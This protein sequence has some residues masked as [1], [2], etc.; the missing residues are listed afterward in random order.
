[1]AQWPF[2]SYR[3]QDSFSE[4]QAVNNYFPPD[5]KILNG[6]NS[7][8]CQRLRPC[9]S[10]AGTWVESPAGELRSHMLCNTAKKNLKRCMEMT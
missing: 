2:Q 5:A 6:G 7:L 4:V 9:T 1:M 3:G 8:T 10:V